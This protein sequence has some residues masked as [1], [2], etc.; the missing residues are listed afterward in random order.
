MAKKIV[1]RKRLLFMILLSV[2]FVVIFYYYGSNI[3]SS[4][5]SAEIKDV[6]TTYEKISVKSLQKNDTYGESA[7]TLAGAITANSISKIKIDP[8]KGTVENLAVNEGDNVAKG[9]VLFNYK[10]VSMELELKEAEAVLTEKKQL[11]YSAEDTETLKWDMYNKASR[12]YTEDQA[13]ELADLK[14]QA[15]IASNDIVNAKAAVDTAQITYQ[16]AVENS[17][18]NVVTASTDGQIKSLNKELL[19]KSDDEKSSDNFIEIVDSSSLYVKGKI[20]EF[21]RESASLE[22]PV[23]IIDRKNPENTWRGKVTKIGYL[24]AEDG[25]SDDTEE[26]ENPNLSKYS[27]TVKLEETDNA[28]LL[29]SNVYVKLLSDSESQLTLPKDYVKE[30]KTTENGQDSKKYFVWKV[31]NGKVKKQEITIDEDKSNGE[32]VVIISG[33]SEEDNIIEASD[34]VKEGIEVS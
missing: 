15:T 23:E 29:G 26:E 5:S 1:K 11:L 33:I 9:Q 25:K 6:H 21:D 24:V 3:K 10:N 13:S 22:Q 30:E 34:E 19:D 16:A 31:I 17:E 18:K 27:Y 2:I 4:V 28:P 32:K 7:V 12:T 8:S 14:M 20:S